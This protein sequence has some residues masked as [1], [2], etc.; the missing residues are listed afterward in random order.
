MS[1][2]LDLVQQEISIVKADIKD[3]VGQIGRKIGE[4]DRMLG[5]AELWMS[6]VMEALQAIDARISLLE[7]KQAVIDSEGG[8]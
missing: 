8:E 3:M 6:K 1:S 4:Q 5:Q 2:P 7:K